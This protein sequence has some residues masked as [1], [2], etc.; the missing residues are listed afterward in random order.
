M[1]LLLAQLAIERQVPARVVA[2]HL[3]GLPIGNVLQVLQQAHPEQD[4]G[5]NGHAPVVDAI[6][7]LQLGS[8]LDQHRINLLG[9]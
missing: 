5:L 3:H 6:A 2:H 4:Y 8:G 1:E 7:A 9:H